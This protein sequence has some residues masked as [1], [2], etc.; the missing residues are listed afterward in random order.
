ML[1]LRSALPCDVDCH[2]NQ[3]WLYPAKKIGALKA[4]ISAVY[5]S[6]TVAFTVSSSVVSRLL[7]EPLKESV[8]GGDGSALN[9]LELGEIL[10]ANQL[11]SA[12]TRD[13][14]EVGYI[15][16]RHEHRDLFSVFVNRIFQFFIPANCNSKLQ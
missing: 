2:G 7:I 13:A 10:L 8:T 1:F 16:D 11:V 3:T 12:G 4:P 15:H 5:G 6:L 14:E 9:D